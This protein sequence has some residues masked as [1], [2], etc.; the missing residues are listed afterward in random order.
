M[1]SLLF[2]LL[3]LLPVPASAC[4]CFFTQH[5]CDYAGGYLEWSPDSTVIARVKFEEFRT[6]NVN[7]FA[8]LYDFKVLDVLVG[9]YEAPF[10]TLWGQDGGNCNGPV[11]AL[12][13]GRDY[14]VLFT[15]Y[16]GYSTYYSGLRGGINNR[17]P[18]HDYLGCG[19]ATLAINRG[20][21]TGPLG[22]GKTSV[23]LNNLIPF[24]EECTGVDVESP[25]GFFDLPS[26]SARVWPNPTNG[27]FMVGFGK[28]TPIY[29]ASLYDMRGRLIE[30]E[31][32]DGSLISEHEISLDKVPAG[33]YQLVMQTDGISVKKRVVVI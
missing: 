17:Y 9:E 19:P 28:P 1:R 21:V 23:S 5:F 7:G 30:E 20:R 24:L 12:R 14:I 27:R 6:P 11:M 32:L 2:F 31:R 29:S 8:P 16:T 22:P 13:E 33:V 4:L 26:Y 18:I 25:G 10:V 3:L 15:S